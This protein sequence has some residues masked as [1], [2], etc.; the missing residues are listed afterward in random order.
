MGTYTY[1]PN[2]HSVINVIIIGTYYN[3]RSVPKVLDS[4][5]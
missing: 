1:G 5:R 4:N 3:I 2:I